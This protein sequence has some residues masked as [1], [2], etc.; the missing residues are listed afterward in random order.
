MTSP[1]LA[2]FAV[3]FVVV[4]DPF[5]DVA[6]VPIPPG[7]QSYTPVVEGLSTLKRDLTDLEPLRF[8]YKFLILLSQHGRKSLALMS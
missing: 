5:E 2:G 1:Q 3:V 8:L 6:A 4:A 7:L